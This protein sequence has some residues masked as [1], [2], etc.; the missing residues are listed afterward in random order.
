MNN[1]KYFLYLR[2]STDREDMQI[3]SID[4]QRTTCETF[5]V[6]AGIQIVDTLI[7]RQSAR[8]PGRPIFRN[9]L[10]RL[11]KGEADGILAYH[12]NR[13]ARNSLDGGEI[14]YGLDTQK[15]K[16]LKFPTFWFENTPQGKA[17]LGIEFVQSK[18]YSDDLAVVTKRGLI[19]K[20]RMG[21]YPG[22]AP[23]GYLNDRNTGII[24]V[25]PGLAPTIREMFERFA[26]GDETIETLRVFLASQGLVS[27]RSERFAGFKPVD[28]KL[29]RKMLSNPI[30][31][32]AF[33]YIGEVYEGKHEPIISKK[34]FDDVQRVLVTRAPTI[35]SRSPQKP[36]TRLIRCGSCGMS[37]TAEVQKSHT[38]YR[39]S[40]KSKQIACRSPFIREEELEKSL[41]I[42]LFQFEM[43]AEVANEFNSRIDEEAKQLKSG[44]LAQ[45]S[46]KRFQLGIVAKKLETLLGIYLAEET[47]RQSFV[48]QQNKLQS[49]R[50][51]LKGEID[52]IERGEFQWLER[53]RKW[54]NTAKNNGHVAREGTLNQKRALAVEIFGSN[55]RLLDGKL[56]GKAVEPWFSKAETGSHGVMVCA[57]PGVREYFRGFGGDEG[58]R[59][60]QRAEAVK[61]SLGSGLNR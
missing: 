18:R 3:L 53:F 12:P 44:K 31:Y 15:V 23:R 36:L 21:F 37:I 24:C 55:L 22:V 61:R 35:R 14:I 49:E 10:E 47:D 17:M 20:C 40:R 27:E 60:S 58:I 4:G 33:R 52:Q 48:R 43:S 16:D 29:V 25:D 57:Y 39:C 56:S 45:L 6:S 26:T 19:Q 54:V 41:S 8:L 9:M 5:A 2:K 32:G 30:Y 51:T 28:P 34:L 7:E 59:T 46:E 13:L 42:Q 11:A 50:A 1:L 38:Y